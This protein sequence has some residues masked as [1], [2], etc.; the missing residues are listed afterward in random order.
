MD[1]VA[2]M[3]QLDSKEMKVEEKLLHLREYVYHMLGLENSSMFYHEHGKFLARYVAGFVDRIFELFE[4]IAYIIF[5]PLH[6]INIIQS[7]AKGIFLHP[8]QTFKTIA[9]VLIK[10]H[11][12]PYGLGVLTAEA[13][14]LTLSAAAVAKVGSLVVEAEEG[15][16]AAEAATEVVAEGSVV[17]GAAET[18]AHRFEDYEEIFRQIRGNPHEIIQHAH[19]TIKTGKATGFIA[20][21]K[22][23]FAV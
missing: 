7:F 13:F 22:N 6:I 20:G 9:K 11:T 3:K 1:T 19:H 4:D 23:F 18:V 10:K 8:I 12:T 5:D 17:G 16:I 15:I 21:V 14:I 2:L